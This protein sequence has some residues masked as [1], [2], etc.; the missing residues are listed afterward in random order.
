M[1]RWKLDPI[2]GGGEDG[3]TTFYTT[4]RVI[5]SFGRGLGAHSGEAAAADVS[6]GHSAE[7]GEAG[8][9]G[10]VGRGAECG[11]ACQP[12]G[13]TRRLCLWPVAAEARPGG[14]GGVSI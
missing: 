6:A 13:R 11:P 2:G 10:A 9:R 1:G 12:G 5:N 7:S 4:S 14:S 8:W 3:K